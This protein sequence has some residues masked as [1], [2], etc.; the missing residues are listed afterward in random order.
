MRTVNL[1]AESRTETGKGPARQLRRQGRVPATL[2]G[3]GKQPVSISVNGKELSTLLHAGTSEHLIVNLSV[4]QQPSELTI[5]RE[6]KHDPLSGSIEHID[7]FRISENKPVATQV[8]LNFVGSS[9]GQRAGGV[10]EQHLREIEVLCLPR[11]IPDII[12]YDISAMEIGTTVHVKELVAP[13]GVKILTPEDHPIAA[14]LSPTKMVEPTEGVAA[15][16]AAE[17]AAAAD[18]AA[19]D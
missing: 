5:L 12:E 17:G 3:E 2:Y 13:E 19:E 14:V 1:G 4:N 7:F 11:L 15:E 10:F 16:A 18:Q 6:A 8:R 9:A